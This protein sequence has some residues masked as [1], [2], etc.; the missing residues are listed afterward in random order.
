MVT[1][2]KTEDWPGG[3]IIKLY[4]SASP[5][6]QSLTVIRGHPAPCG[7]SSCPDLFFFL[8]VRCNLQPLFPT[9]MLH[10]RLATNFIKH[11][12]ASED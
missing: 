6:L 4:P 12:A 8:H 1:P 11:L 5:R 7:G 2:F 3:K 9:C 10:S